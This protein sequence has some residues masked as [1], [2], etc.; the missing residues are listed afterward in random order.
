[1]PT[2]PETNSLPLKIGKL[3]IPKGNNRLP[4]IHFQGRAVSFREGKFSFKIQV[5]F[6]P[7]T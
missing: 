5:G 7:R 6:G 2:L 1:M 4:T 3:A